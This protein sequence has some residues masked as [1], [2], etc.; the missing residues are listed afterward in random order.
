MCRPPCGPSRRFFQKPEA[1]GGRH[2]ECASTLPPALDRP[3]QQRQQEKPTFR[4]GHRGQCQGQ[5]TEEEKPQTH[6]GDGPPQ[7]VER[8]HHAEPKRGIAYAFGTRSDEFRM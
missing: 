2:T 5:T 7:Q 1:S 8:Q 4:A 6:F 3:E